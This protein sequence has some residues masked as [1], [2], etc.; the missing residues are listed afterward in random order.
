MSIRKDTI[1]RASSKGLIA[2]SG[3][4]VHLNTGETVEGKDSE[5]VQPVSCVSHLTNFKGTLIPAGEDIESFN[6]S[7]DVTWVLIVEKEVCIDPELGWTD[8]LNV[9]KAVFQ[10][11]CRLWATNHD[12]FPGPGLIITVNLV[13][14]PSSSR[15]YL[16]T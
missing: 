3:I 14:L 11:L 16:P 5:V 9:L 13:F 7:M 8:A 15:N 2:G 12:L 10:T 6:I 4:S 1:Q